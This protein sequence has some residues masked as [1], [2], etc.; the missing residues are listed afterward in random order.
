[1]C[2]IY[3]Y[4]LKLIGNGFNILVWWIVILHILLIKNKLNMPLLDI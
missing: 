2:N 1:M 4:N 3:N